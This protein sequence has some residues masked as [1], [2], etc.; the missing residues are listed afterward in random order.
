MNFSDAERSSCVSSFV[1]DDEESDTTEAL[2]VFK[3]VIVMRLIKSDPKVCPYANR[4]AFK[5]ERRLR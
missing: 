1:P 3:G 4:A 5:F 2:K